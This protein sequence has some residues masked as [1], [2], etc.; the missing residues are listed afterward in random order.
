MAFGGIGRSKLVSQSALA[1]IFEEMGCQK[2]SL[3]AASR[4]RE[5]RV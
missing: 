4:E 1:S 2:Q 3:E 5:M